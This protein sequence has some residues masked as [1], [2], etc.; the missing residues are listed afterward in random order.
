MI[1]PSL[2]DQ[3]TLIVAGLLCMIVILAAAA[4]YGLILALR[5]LLQ[6]YALARPSARGLHRTPTPQGGGIAIVL[7]FAVIGG[8]AAAVFIGLMPMP[9]SFGAR[10]VATLAAAAAAACALGAFD[11]IRPLSPFLRLALQFLIAA[12]ALTVLPAGAQALPGFVP[13]WL[14]RTIL[15]VG[16]VW[17]VNL[18]NFMDGMDL[19]TAAGF[20][21]A[22]AGLL[23]LTGTLDFPPVPGMMAAALLGGLLGFAPFNWPVA[24]LFLGDAGSLAIGLIVGTL[25]VLLAVQGHL[26]AAL[27]LCLYHLADSTIT[28]LRR[29]V[30]GAKVWEA[31]R[32]HFYQQAAMKGWSAAR[33]AAWVFGLNAILAALA[34][35]TIYADATVAA[36]LLLCGAALTGWTLGSFSGGLA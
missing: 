8:L 9:Q 21:P 14:E 1:A 36:L 23:V 27:L 24:R 19:M 3:I 26:A 28:L 18:T 2:L 29:L 16:L 22:L 12:A 5:P 34:I 15:L 32:E 20:V 30:R 35:G 33:V 31:H 25:L 7:A 17:F 11:D 4:T 13:I 6:R 10:Q